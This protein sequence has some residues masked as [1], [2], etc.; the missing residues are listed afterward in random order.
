M[1]H[2]ANL[3]NFVYMYICIGPPVYSCVLVFLCLLCFFNPRPNSMPLRVRI[4]KNK[5]N[6]RFSL[7]TAIKFFTRDS[8]SINYFLLTQFILC[9]GPYKEW[10]KNNDTLFVLHSRLP[11][12]NSFKFHIIFKEQKK[13]NKSFRVE[14]ANSTSTPPPAL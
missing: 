13:L 9:I 8:S 14:G 6:N 2:Y 11:S 3:C 7:S 1:S 10:L 5:T 12:F 4:M